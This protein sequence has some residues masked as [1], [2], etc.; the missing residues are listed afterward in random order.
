MIIHVVVVVVVL[1]GGGSGVTRIGEGGGGVG[2]DGRL[3]SWLVLVLV[4]K[5]H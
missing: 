3:I 5:T 4:L 2:V 1:C